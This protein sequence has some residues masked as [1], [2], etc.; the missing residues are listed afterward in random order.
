MASINTLVDDFNGPFVDGVTWTATGS[1]VAGNVFVNNNQVNI[2]H[3]PGA[4]TNKFSTVATYDLTGS[5]AYVQVKSYGDTSQAN[6]S[7]QFYMFLD[8]N[9]YYV[10]YTGG[11]TLNAASNIAAT[12][13]STPV[14]TIGDANR[15]L[16]IRESGGTVFWDT[17]PDGITWTNQSSVAAGF[18][19]TSLEVILQAQTSGDAKGNQGI[20]DNFNTLDKSPYTYRPVEPGNP[21]VGP[22]PLRLRR[23]GFSTRWPRGDDVAVSVDTTITPGAGSLI[24]T[25][26]VRCWIWASFPVVVH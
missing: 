5:A 9:N 15:W 24:L 4:E 13:N 2:Y 25:G 10:F 1:S 19:I 17:S 21:R 12:F 11:T 20:F 8:G 6:H 16:R 18:A 22:M 3:G 23:F 14:G 7:V 26:S